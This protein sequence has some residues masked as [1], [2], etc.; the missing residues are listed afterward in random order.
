MLLN[1]QDLSYSD[2]YTVYDAINNSSE[3]AIHGGAVFAFASESGIEL[4]FQ[5]E[6]IKSILNL[7]SFLLVV[8]IDDIT[9]ER[10][11]NKLLSLMEEYPNLVVKAYYKNGNRGIF[12]PKFLWFEKEG[13]I[14]NLLVGSGNLTLRGFKENVE[15]FTLNQLNTEE[16]LSV[17]EKFFS[18]I[19]ESSVYLKELNDESVIERVRENKIQVVRRPQTRVTEEVVTEEDTTDIQ[20]EEIVVNIDYEQDEWS[21]DLNNQVLVAEIPKSGSRWKQVNF[22]KTV[23]ENF[24]GAEAHGMNQEVILLRNVNNEGNLQDIETRPAVSVASDNYRFELNAASG[25][26]YPNEGAPIGIFIKVTPGAFI[27][28]LVFPTENIYSDILDFLDANAVI[29]RT[30]E[31]K[32]VISTCNEIEA[33][34][35]TLP[36]E[37]FRI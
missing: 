5:L 24:F 35:S 2:N 1:I 13:N 27:Y 25:I 16:T 19:D 20:P 3:N 21:F 18:W 33:I 34:I 15:A 6:N 30:G 29:R 12:H 22:S 4:L 11:I 37:E 23:F 7:G 32:R 17:K 14:G 8:G 9:N 36:L 26:P 10:A 31:K 28:V